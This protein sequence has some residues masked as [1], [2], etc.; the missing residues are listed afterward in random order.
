V[1]AEALSRKGQL[2]EALARLAAPLHDGD[3]EVRAQAVGKLARIEKA[4]GRGDEARRAFQDAAALDRKTGRVSS[5]ASDRFAWA[6][7]LLFGGRR[8]SEARGVLE[9]VHALEDTD[10]NA[11]AYRPY[12]EGLLANETG[13]LRSALRLFHEAAER[14]ARLD[15]ADRLDPMV[16]R[17]HILQSLGRGEE[18]EATI[19]EVLGAL[20][21][22]VPPCLRAER[23]ENIGWFVLRAREGGEPLR[24]LAPNPLPGLEE[25][26]SLARSPACSNPE[27]VA[28]VLTDLA[29]AMVLEGRPGEAL[30]YLREAQGAYPGADVWLSAWWLDIDARIALESGRAQAALDAYE[31]LA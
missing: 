20:G 21:A 15:F 24:R 29:L 23:L 18:G 16:Q 4:R 25:A 3:D 22:D 28:N 31:R 2:Y 27:D 30:R 6:Y 9:P 7:T 13:D 26:L 10:P 12:F 19:A 5:E 17:A 14:Q 8:F 11:R 1:E